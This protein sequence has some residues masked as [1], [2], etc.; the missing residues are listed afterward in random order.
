MVI[1]SLTTLIGT[2]LALPIA[3]ELAAT[4]IEGIV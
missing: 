3:D 4:F 2:S 1:L